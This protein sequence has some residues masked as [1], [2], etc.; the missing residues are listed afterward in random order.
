MPLIFS[1]TQE[2]FIKTQLL[3]LLPYFLVTIQ[4]YL[5]KIQPFTFRSF[6][7]LLLLLTF[8]R[9]RWLQYSLEDLLLGLLQRLVSLSLF[10]ISDLLDSSLVVSMLSP[11]LYYSLTNGILQCLQL[12]L[13]WQLCGHCFPNKSCKIQWIRP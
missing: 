9:L 3:N 7:L 4:F 5:I 8:F 10:G 11:R 2:I 1:L 13:L 12:R 6:D